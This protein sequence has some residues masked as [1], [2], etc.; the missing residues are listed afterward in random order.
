MPT[1]DPAAPDPAAP[2]P[3]TAPQP[4]ELP[5]SPPPSPPLEP[6]HT[7]SL[8]PLPPDT[9]PP[10][11]SAAAPASA[12]KPSRAR[13]GRAAAGALV[14][15]AMFLAGSAGVAVGASLHHVDSTAAPAA[16]TTSP[17]TTPPGAQTLPTPQ[18]APAA[19]TPRTSPRGGFGGG[20]GGSGGTGGGGSSSGTGS[21]AAEQI[22]AAVDP[23]VVDIYDTLTDGEAAG[24][25]IVLTSQ[26]LVL[27]N[28]HVIA[29]A[30]SIRVQVD[31]TGPTYKADVLG[32]DTTADVALLQLDGASDL[33]P[34][35][36]ADSSSVEVGDAVVAL[37]NA[38]GQGGTPDVVTGTVTGLDQ[39]IT[40]SDETGQNAE[41]LDGLIAVNAALQPGDSGGPL[42][43]ESGQVI[44]MDTAAYASFRRTTGS[45]YAIPIDDALAIARQIQSGSSSD[46]VHIGDR[47]LLGVEIEDSSGAAVVAAV[48]PSSPAADIGLA[49]GDTIVAVDG[50]TISDG[51]SLRS[52]LDPYHPGDR[53]TLSWTDGSGQRH[54]A[55]ATLTDGPPA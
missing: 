40:V 14:A 47:A 12:P 6:P 2:A 26:G 28:N 23:S 30:T 50:T 43:N 18:T 19:P 34:A 3:A 11:A 1:F 25:G 4:S 17:T 16:V 48:E 24:T 55:Q 15:A 44:G 38:L 9:P 37:G 31:G 27:T 36:I 53:V 22:A 51:A 46:D 54:Q 7:A 35:P 42:V 8:P 49:E 20:T 45:G 32:Y 39:S 29:D 5:H 52:A 21:A 10:A 33:Q 13:L 41:H